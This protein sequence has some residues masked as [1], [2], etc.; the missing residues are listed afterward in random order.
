MQGLREVA[1]AY[2]RLRKSPASLKTLKKL[3]AANPSALAEVCLAKAAL[4]LGVQA[5]TKVIFCGLALVCT[6]RT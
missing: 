2:L 4:L 6:C 5:A 3:A 1:D